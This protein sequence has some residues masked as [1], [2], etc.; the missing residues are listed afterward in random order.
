MFFFKIKKKEE[1]FSFC[2]DNFNKANRILKKQQ[3]LVF[4][5]SVFKERRGNTE[6]K[7]YE[8][9]NSKKKTRLI[10]VCFFSFE[11]VFVKLL[12]NF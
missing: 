1:L 12:F 3:N 10:R 5:L 9:Q 4:Y 7:A 6:I 11:S 2:F 8:K